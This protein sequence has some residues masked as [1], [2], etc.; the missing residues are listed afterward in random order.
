MPLGGTQMNYNVIAL[1]PG[2]STGWS[3]WKHGK[4]INVGVAQSLE[5]VIQ[6]F[7]ILGPACTHVV[8]E[9]FTW[10]NVSSKEQVQTIE[11]CGSIETLSR[12]FNCEP[13][14]QYPAV[15]RGY[16]QFAKKVTTN[17]PTDIKRHAIDSIAH[18]YKFYDTLHK[19]G[20]IEWDRPF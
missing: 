16:L 11:M 17:I 15:R 12:L 3:W 7:E 9:G 14:K 4:L 19:E 8:Y 20:M 18:A 2:L 10:N 13:V 6:L 1:D 5:E